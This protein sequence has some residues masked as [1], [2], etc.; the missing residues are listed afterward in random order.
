MVYP[1][2]T[3]GLYTFWFLVDISFPI[4]IFIDCCRYLSS[5]NSGYGFYVLIIYMTM[6]QSSPEYLGRSAP[7]S[8]DWYQQKIR[9]CILP[10]TANHWIKIDIRKEFQSKKPVSVEAWHGTFSSYI[11]MSDMHGA[12]VHV[13]IQWILIFYFQI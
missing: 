10:R 13:Y 4:C 9:Y 5:R 6:S 12:Y 11:C 1:I 8:C 7:K 2:E 3:K